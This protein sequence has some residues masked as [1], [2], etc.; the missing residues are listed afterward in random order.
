LGIFDVTNYFIEKNTNITRSQKKL[1]R[2][3]WSQRIIKRES[4]GVLQILSSNSQPQHDQ[5]K[6]NNVEGRKRNGQK[7]T[8]MQKTEKS[9]T[10]GYKYNPKSFNSSNLVDEEYCKN[11]KRFK[12]QMCNN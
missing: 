2:Y 10:I 11:R 6:G 1:K 8:I 12:S 7:Q 4:K 3:V 9:T 5:G